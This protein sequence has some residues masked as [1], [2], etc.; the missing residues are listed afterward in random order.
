MLLKKSTAVNRPFYL[1]VTSLTPSVSLSKD[2]GA[3]GAA[4]GSV[5]EISAGWY[6]LA[7]TTADTGTAGG[8]AWSITGTGVPPLIGQPV[9][10]VDAPVS[11]SGV[12][13]E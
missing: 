10:Q 13:T 9:D 8:L 12:V 5:T 3:F 2:G 4:A 7:M 11:I 1:G 6:N